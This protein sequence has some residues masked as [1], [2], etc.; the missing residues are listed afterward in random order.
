MLLNEA[1][2]KSRTISPGLVVD[3]THIYQ[4]MA[5]TASIS[6]HEVA[7]QLEIT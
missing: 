5:D 6:L 7:P 3:V 4:Q 2:S 1:R